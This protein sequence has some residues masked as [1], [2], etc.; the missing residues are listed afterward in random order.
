M[1]KSKARQKKSSKAIR[2]REPWHDE[3]NHE[4]ALTTN[5]EGKR[6]QKKEVDHKKEKKKKQTAKRVVGGE[7]KTVAKIKKAG[8]EGGVVIEL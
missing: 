2:E 5:G 3:P 8:K 1:Q 4:R 7:Q 6:R